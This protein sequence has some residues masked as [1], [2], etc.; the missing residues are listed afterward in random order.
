MKNPICDE[1]I[2]QD[3]CTI[4][5]NRSNNTYSTP[6]KENCTPPPCS[7]DQVLSPNCNCAYPY[8]GSLIF[9]APSFSDYGNKSVF[10]FLE[11]EMMKSFK[12]QNQPVDSVSLSNPLK[13]EVN[14]LVLDLEIFPSNQPYFNRSG[15]TKIGFMLSN[16]TFKPPHEFGPFYFKGNTYQ[17]F[18][19][20][21]H[22]VK[23]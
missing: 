22:F 14:Y 4:S 17:Y 18:A 7:S 3:Y 21:F 23:K 16:Q 9:R 5:H 10:E 12:S 15:I 1:G 11:Q 20:S 13:N 8:S 2:T 6:K 19:G